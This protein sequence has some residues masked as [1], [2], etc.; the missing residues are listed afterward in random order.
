MAESICNDHA[1]APVSVPPRAAAADG[2]SPAGAQADA[3]RGRPP[4]GPVE[5]PAAGQL[6]AHVTIRAPRRWQRFCSLCRAR[7]QR[8]LR[9]RKERQIK[10]Q[11][12]DT[13]TLFNC[14]T[15][16][17]AV[18]VSRELR[19]LCRL[20]FDLVCIRSRVFTVS[21]IY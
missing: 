4:Q 1:P 14:I 20:H 19:I 17:E 13:I 6:R 3:A 7:V 12:K 9:G 10:K 2:V 8:R 5:G 15:F 11:N 21:H 18:I 16:C